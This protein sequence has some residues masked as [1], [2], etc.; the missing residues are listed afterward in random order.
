MS[1][2]GYS[3]IDKTKKIINSSQ[4]STKKNKIAQLQAIAGGIAVDKITRDH[5]HNLFL[6]PGQ[7]LKC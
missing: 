1:V 7:K 2:N 4:K 6:R 5:L 3:K